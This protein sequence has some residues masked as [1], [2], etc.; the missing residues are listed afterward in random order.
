MKR[1][2]SVPKTIQAVEKGVVGP[3]GG[4]K[5]AQNE[6]KTLRKRRFQPLFSRAEERAKEFFNTLDRFGNT[7]LRS[8]E[9]RG[10]DSISSDVARFLRRLTYGVQTHPLL[11]AR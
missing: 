7:R 10:C 3:I 9:L 8:R 5:E 1:A 11:E 6:A 2:D 4:P